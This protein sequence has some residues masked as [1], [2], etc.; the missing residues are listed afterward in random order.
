MKEVGFCPFTSQF[1]TS[2]SLSLPFSIKEESL[3]INELTLYITHLQ[4]RCSLYLAHLYFSMGKQVL[5]FHLPTV[6][7]EEHKSADR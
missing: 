2:P 1:K 4:L 7:E 6:Q 3:I 5:M